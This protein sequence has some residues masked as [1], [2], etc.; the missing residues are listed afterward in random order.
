MNI[1]HEHPLRILRYSI[2]NIWLL[3]FPL[4]RG[5]RTLRFNRSWFYEWLQGAWFDIMILGLIVIFGLFQWY[6]SRIIITS[7]SITHRYGI[8]FRI[9]TTIPFCNISSTSFESP[10]YLSPFGAVKVRCDT[11]A[12]IFKSSDMK[13]MVNRR[14]MPELKSKLP[15][16]KAGEASCDF[17]KAS[18]IS[19]I[20]FSI[21]FS[22]GF[23]GTVYLATFFFKGGDIARDMIGTYL[24]RITESTE[25]FTGKL[26]Q[27]IPDAAVG[28]GILFVGAWL[29]SFFINITRYYAFSLNTSDRAIKLNYGLFNRKEYTLVKEHI[30]YIDIRQ[31]MIMKGFRA[32]AVHVSCA[33]YGNSRKSLPVLLPVRRERGIRED[34]VKIG[35]NRGDKSRFKP[36]WTGY[37]QYV[38]IP[39]LTSLSLVPVYMIVTRV[40]PMLNTLTVFVAV[41][42][43]VPAVWL[44]AVKTVAFFTSG[45]SIY[46]DRI[47]LHY[48]RFT[49]FHTIIADRN[50]LVKVELEQTIFQKIGRRGSLS[51]WFEGETKRRH[52]I[53]A[54]SEKNIAIISE[55]LD[56]ELFK[57]IDA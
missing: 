3:I 23:S 56:I 42:T 57:L 33:G 8:V 1:Y 27:R 55:M 12:G 43:E 19:V 44:I 10:I 46:D 13:V 39:V 31:N 30:N 48:N 9:K 45:I 21:F 37:W 11:R 49:T 25:K 32:I 36:V 51:F 34:L 24:D 16:I 53:R 35:I 50:K 47:K 18:A 54:L 7:S 20:L 52:K 41:M 5:I 40:I 26:L 28:L 14:I 6:F 22:S 2:K 17:P 15:G 29:I 38:W 4:L